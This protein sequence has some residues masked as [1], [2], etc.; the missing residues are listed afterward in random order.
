MSETPDEPTMVTRTLT[1]HTEGCGNAGHPIELSVPDNV[2]AFACGVC[3]QQI[4]D[5]ST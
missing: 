3:G 5:V 1:C 2:D 4:E